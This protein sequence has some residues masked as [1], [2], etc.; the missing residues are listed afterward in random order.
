MK[1]QHRGDTATKHLKQW[2]LALAAGASLFTGAARADTTISGTQTFTGNPDSYW[3][4]A[5]I[6]TFA[7]GADFFQNTSPQSAPPTGYIISNSLIF[8]GNAILRFNGNDTKRDFRG[9]I[10]G[11]AA[12]NQIIEIRAS[13]GL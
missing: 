11:T 12:G 10:S 4:T 9:P 8:Q 3:G 7:P 6:V 2:S 13:I 1:K 5:G